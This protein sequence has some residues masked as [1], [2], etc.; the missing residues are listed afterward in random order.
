MYKGERIEKKFPDLFKNWGILIGNSI[1]RKQ[2]EQELSQLFNFAPDIITVT[3]MDGFIKK[4]NPA[5]TRLLGYSEEE[6]VNSPFTNYV[7]PDD[8]EKTITLLAGL[9]DKIATVDIENRC[10]TKPGKSHLA[11]MDH[12]FIARRRISYMQL[13]KKLQKKKNWKTCSTKPMPLPV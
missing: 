6:L 4:I 9:V 10:I 2:V 1:R 11:F 7:H 5:A 8:W 13:P 12:Y 3:G